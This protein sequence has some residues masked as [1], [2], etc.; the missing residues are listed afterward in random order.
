[1]FD[2]IFQHA[3]SAKFRE[4]LFDAHLSEMFRVLKPGGW[5]EVYGSPAHIVDAGPATER[6]ILA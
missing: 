5:V 1:T 4:N 6:F 3:V 2:F